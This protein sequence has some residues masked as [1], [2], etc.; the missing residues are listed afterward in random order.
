[1]KAY[2]QLLIFILFSS[3]V[4]SQFNLTIERK[5]VSEKCIMGYLSIQGVASCYTLELPYRDNI[6]DFSAIPVGVFDAKIR[7]D[8]NKGWRIELVN[9][10]NRGNIQIHVGN[11]TSETMGCFLVGVKANIDDC[12]VSDSKKALKKI[13]ERLIAY[14]QDLC[15]DC[16]STNEYDISVDV[17]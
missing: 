8:G 5:L 16:N 17:K 4:F 11:F 15:L 10:S 1:M 3:S 13:E 14:K 12:S 7:T 9:V 2:T 6:N